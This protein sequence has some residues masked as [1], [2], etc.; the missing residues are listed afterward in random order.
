MDEL[1]EMQAQMALLKDKLNKEEIVND[2]LLREVTRQRVRHLNR[3]VRYNYLLALPLLAFMGWNMHYLNCS[4]YFTCTT[5]LMLL[6]SFITLIVAHSR[7]KQQDIINGNLLE[8][9]KQVRRFRKYYVDMLR[10]GM[11]VILVWTVW[12]FAELYFHHFNEDPNALIAMGLGGIIGG[13][14][15]GIVSW[16]QRKKYLREID[17]LIKQIEQPE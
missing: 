7:I 10:I 4:W 9:A 8:V 5:L 13:L 12:F 1:Q 16:I 14:S 6:A 17:E 3:Y 2:Q 15:G 11:P